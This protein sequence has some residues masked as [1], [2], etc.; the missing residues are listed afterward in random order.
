MN[1]THKAAVSFIGRMQK[2]AKTECG[3]IVKVAA[4][5]VESDCTCPECRTVIDRNWDLPAEM[6]KDASPE[7]LAGIEKGRKLRYQTARFETLLGEALRAGKTE[8]R[9]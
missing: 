5:A 4:L 2:T 7:T 1:I 8:A 9:S 3:K 6:L